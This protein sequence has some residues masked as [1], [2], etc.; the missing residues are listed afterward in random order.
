MTIPEPPAPPIPIA[1][2]ECLTGRAVRYDGSD[3]WSLFPHDALD[4]LF[5][6]V[7][8]CPEMGIGMDVPRPPIQLAGAPSAPRVVGV[9]DP[10]MD[11]TEK[12]AEF[13]RSRSAQIEA[14]C[15]YVFMER[16]PSC[17]LYTVPVYALGG[18]EVV[19]RTGRGGYARI[20]LERHPMLP[21]EENGRLFD[22][23]IRESFIARAFAYA[24]WRR[25]CET[26]PTIAGLMEFHSCY[27]Y[28]LM[29]HSVEH[30]RRAGRLLGT[31]RE[32]SNPDARCSQDSPP[33]VA[34]PPSQSAEQDLQRP[35]PPNS[36]SRPAATLSQ[37]AQEYLECL[38]AGLGRP[39]TR[40]GHAN[41]LSH[42]QGYL[43]ELLTDSERRE[44]T[45]S[46]DDY[47]RGATVLA[48]PHGLLLHHLQS[49]PQPYLAKQVYLRNAWAVGLG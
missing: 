2:S 39:A 45:A 15:G 42:I 17:G 26:G 43:S 38:L 35:L 33:R 4:G 29:A 9:R 24:H 3:A 46:I 32:P 7:P 16:S 47:R 11:V 30:Y 18:D 21:A 37:L 20:L 31:W 14:V 5:S 13:A 27:K 48:D 28:L 44:L 19:S 23:G 34:T 40:G 12:L 25:L 22:S 49:Y 10:G 1:I 8:I 41:A 36:E 6:H